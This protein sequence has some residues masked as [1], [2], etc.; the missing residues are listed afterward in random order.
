MQ[1][2]IFIDPVVLSTASAIIRGT[3]IVVG[4]LLIAAFIQLIRISLRD[5]Q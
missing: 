3:G 1:T 2:N 5:E 4:I